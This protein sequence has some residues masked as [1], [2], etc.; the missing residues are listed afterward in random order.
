M[1]NGESAVIDSMNVYNYSIVMRSSFPVS[2]SMIHHKPSDDYND[3]RVDNH[4]ANHWAKRLEEVSKKDY[5]SADSTNKEF[6]IQKWMIAALNLSVGDATR[7]EIPIASSKSEEPKL[8]LD[9]TVIKP[10]GSGVFGTRGTK[11]ILSGYIPEEDTAPHLPTQSTAPE[12]TV[13]ES[14]APESTAPE[15]AKD[16]TAPPDLLTSDPG[17]TEDLREWRPLM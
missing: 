11:I 13:P 9:F 1:H 12:S 10:P 3:L 2:N 4:F 5:K 15:L 8:K 17:L 14:A 16:D 6:L 7:G